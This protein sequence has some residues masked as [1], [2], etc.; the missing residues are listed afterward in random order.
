MTGYGERIRET[1]KSKKC[2]KGTQRTHLYLFNEYLQQQFS[3]AA[4]NAKQQICVLCCVLSCCVVLCC[5]VTST[6]VYRLHICRQS[7]QSFHCEYLITCMYNV[8]AVY[9]NVCEYLLFLYEQISLNQIFVPL[10]EYVYM[11]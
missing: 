8:C 10:L 7:I 2:E 1:V 11:L 6:T 4:W 9:A 5:L 3:I